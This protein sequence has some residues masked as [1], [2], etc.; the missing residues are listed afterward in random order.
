MSSL[1]S[2]VTGRRMV[3]LRRRPVVPTEALWRDAGERPGKGILKSP[4]LIH[5]RKKRRVRWAV[6]LASF[7]YPLPISL[8]CSLPTLPLVFPSLRTHHLVPVVHAVKG[9]RLPLAM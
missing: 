1:V 7:P 8:T 6:S 4:G 5:P 2:A 9:R 3:V